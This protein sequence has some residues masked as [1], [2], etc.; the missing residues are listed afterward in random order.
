MA[1]YKIVGKEESEEIGNL[2]TEKQNIRP[3]FYWLSRQ[4]VEKLMVNN[5]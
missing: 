2:H 4:A 5:H 3:F 1:E